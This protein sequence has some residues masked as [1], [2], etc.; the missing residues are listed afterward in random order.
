MLVDELQYEY[1]IK[2]FKVQN[3]EVVLLICL[4]VGLLVN[5][6]YLNSWFYARAYC[7]DHVC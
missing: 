3:V 4:F 6:Y 2:D 7:Q 5:F 1:C